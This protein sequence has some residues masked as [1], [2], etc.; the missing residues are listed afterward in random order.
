MSPV[1]E[2]NFFVYDPKHPGWSGPIKYLD[3]VVKSLPE[4]MQLYSGVTNEKA[5]GEASPSNLSRYSCAQIKY[6]LPKGR[7]IGI[8]RQPV[9]HAYA[10]FLHRR[11][12]GFEPESD[13]YTA[14]RASDL[15]RKKNWSPMLVYRSDV[16]VYNVKNWLSNFPPEQIRFFLTDDLKSDARGL[17]KDIYRFL[18]IDDSFSPDISKRYNTAFTVRMPAVSRFFQPQSRGTPLNVLLKKIVPAPLR[19]PLVKQV[20]T[21]NRLPAPPLDPGIRNELTAELREDILKLQDLLNR[22]LSHWFKER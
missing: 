12:D 18:N 17:M 5:I 16:Y 4:Y 7:F 1:K 11:R 20:H 21:W 8:L 2:P 22:D 3:A 6:H 19:S 9:D 14:Y 13:F 10:K 15:R